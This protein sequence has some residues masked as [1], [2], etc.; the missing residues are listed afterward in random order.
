[1]T[2]AALLVTTLGLAWVAASPEHVGTIWMAVFLVA[3]ASASQDIAVD[4]YAV[5]VLR[6][7]EQGLAAGARAASSRFALTLSGRLSITAATWPSWPFLFAAQPSVYPRAMVPMWLSPEPESPPAPPRTLRAAVWEPFVAFLRQNRA[8]E[9]TSFLVLYKFGDNL[10]T[11]LV[12]PFL[13]EMGY[14]KM[15]VGLIF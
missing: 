11:A 8:I 13:L 6:P 2:Q 15:D 12:S 9:I 7:E 3:F 5:E 4:A 14:S 1:I 10:A